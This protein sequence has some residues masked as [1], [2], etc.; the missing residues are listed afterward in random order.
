MF[1]TRGLMIKIGPKRQEASGG[2]AFIISLS[3]QVLTG[4]KSTTMEWQGT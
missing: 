1:K 4:I 3:H 2:L